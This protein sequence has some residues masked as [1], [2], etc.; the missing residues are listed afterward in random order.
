M[1]FFLHIIMS[2]Y[3]EKK[4]AATAAAAAAATAAARN[5]SH[6]VKFDGFL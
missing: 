3:V 4:A 6:H 1:R 2:D 5:I